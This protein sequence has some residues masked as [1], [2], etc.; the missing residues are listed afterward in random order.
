MDFTK[1][2]TDFIILAGFHNFFYSTAEIPEKQ[3]KFGN[4]FFDYVTRSIHSFPDP[5]RLL[6]ITA[7]CADV[8]YMWQKQVP[9]NTGVDFFSTG[10]VSH[11]QY[12]RFSVHVARHA[13][14]GF[15]LLPAFDRACLFMVYLFPAAHYA[16]TKQ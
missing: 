15:Y 13:D 8:A 4:T 10:S 11:L 16:P 3:R 7:L 12:N 1:S 5:T 6:R 14:V 2:F 9:K